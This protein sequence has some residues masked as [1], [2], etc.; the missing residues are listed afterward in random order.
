MHKKGTITALNLLL[1][2]NYL[3]FNIWGC[4]SSAYS[5]LLW[6]SWECVLYLIII[7][8]SEVWI[9]NHCLGL[10]HK[11][12]YPLYVSLCSYEPFLLICFA[13]WKSWYY[14]M[15]GLAQ[16]AVLGLNVACI[17]IYRVYLMKPHVWLYLRATSGNLNDDSRP[18]CVWI[19][20]DSVSVTQCVRFL[21]SL[22]SLWYQPQ[23]ED[24][25]VWLNLCNIVKC[26]M[27]N[28][29]RRSNKTEHQ[30]TLYSLNTLDSDFESVPKSLRAHISFKIETE[31]SSGWLPWSSSLVTTRAIILT[32][33]PFQSTLI[34]P[35]D[36]GP[37]NRLFS[38]YSQFEV[39]CI[40]GKH[41]VSNVYKSKF[42]W[43]PE[44]N[45][46]IIAGCHEPTATDLTLYTV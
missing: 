36:D 40:Y 1:S 13:V 19:L 37:N 39:R 43:L 38:V 18:T 7:L 6:W 24:Y 10:G 33:F 45:K 42:G 11:K 35:R 5:I 16:N 26:R 31:R 12:W 27:A 46:L 20:S 8:K 21:R 28:T 23:P 14:D 44:Q 17:S 4:V 2:L 34:D 3:L 29:W 15:H 32:A 9:I 25:A 30:R 41:T 22:K